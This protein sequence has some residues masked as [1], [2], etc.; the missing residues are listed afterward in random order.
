MD[1]ELEKQK[2]NNFTKEEFIDYAKQLNIFK[3]IQEPNYLELKT[4]IIGLLSK[5][6]LTENDVMPNKR[7]ARLDIR[8]SVL[9]S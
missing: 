6:N 5:F 7:Q 8:T 9:K 2:I 1:I 4:T 3:T